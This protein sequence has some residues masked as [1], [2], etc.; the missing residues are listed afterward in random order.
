[1]S[2]TPFSSTEGRRL[3]ITNTEWIKKCGY[4]AYNEGPKPSLGEVGN[5]PGET[6]TETWTIAYTSEG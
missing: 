3:K 4:K 6:Q 5:F 2:S 1:M